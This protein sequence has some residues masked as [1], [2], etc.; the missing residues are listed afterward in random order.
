LSI[1][2][3]LIRI[4][5]AN[6]AFATYTGL[7]LAGVAAGAIAAC[8]I[9]FTT[10][11]YSIFWI[12]TVFIRVTAADQAVAMTI[13]GLAIF[14]GAKIGCAAGNDAA[15]AAGVSYGVAVH[16]NRSTIINASSS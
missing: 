13:A 9:I 6:L 15:A 1:T 2:T 4:T 5:T 12:T 8:F 10:V 16:A 11:V 7:A 3:F 14:G